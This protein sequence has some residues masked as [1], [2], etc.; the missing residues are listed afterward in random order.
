MKETFDCCVENE[1][2]GY[3]GD[4]F[5]TLFLTSTGEERAEAD[6][7]WDSLTR[8]QKKLCEL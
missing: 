3:L 8:A 4:W 5:F 6:K 2:W 7:L 1:Q